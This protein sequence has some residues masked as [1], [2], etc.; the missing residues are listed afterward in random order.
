M[1]VSRGGYYAWLQRGPSAH[2]ERDADDY[3]SRSGGRTLGCVAHQL[4]CGAT[5][6]QSCVKLQRVCSEL[7]V[8]CEIYKKYCRNDPKLD[9]GVPDAY[10]PKRDVRPPKMDVRPPKMDVRP[11]K[12]DVR[13]P[14]LDG[15]Q[16]WE[17]VR[18]VFTNSS[19]VETCADGNG[20]GYTCRGLGSCWIKV[21]G[22]HGQKILWKSSCGGYATTVIDGR[23]EDASFSCSAPPPQHVTE[24]VTCHFLSANGRQDC[25]GSN[26]AFCS[27]YGRCRVKVTGARGQTITWKSSCGG[28]VQTRLDGFDESA[29]FYCP[30]SYPDMM[31]WSP[32]ARMPISPDMG[33]GR[34]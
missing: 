13:P 34:D 7:G 5:A 22:Y 4:F 16:S 1:Q 25:Y 24:V 21:G 14:K 15:M 11:P 3:C 19:K 6:A 30:R 27:G 31:P 12:M 8:G 9:F 17:A 23:D 32:D 10:P 2:S 18:C 29:Y 28:Y 26:G 33:V 20:L